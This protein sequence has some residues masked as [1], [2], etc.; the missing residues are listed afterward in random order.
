MNVV[1]NGIY[2]FALSKILTLRSDLPETFLRNEFTRELEVYEKLRLNNDEKV[3]EVPGRKGP[4]VACAGVVSR[5]IL[6]FVLVSPKC[7]QC[8]LRI[9]GI[10]IYWENS[11]II[12]IYSLTLLKQI[13]NTSQCYYH[14]EN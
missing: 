6:R 14:D 11:C 5:L 1:H 8:L 2:I 4:G 7:F 3:G 9:G 13:G 10:V 12:I